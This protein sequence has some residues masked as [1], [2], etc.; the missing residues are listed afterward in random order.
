MQDDVV[1][2]VENVSK[3]FCKSLKRGMLY[4]MFDILRNSFGI[5]TNSEKL[6]LGEF[7][8][9]DD[10]SFEVK[11]GEI[12][13]IIGMN[14]SGKTTLLKMLNG[15]FWPDKGKITIHGRTGAL[16]ALG[17]GF[18]PNLTGRENIFMNGAILG[19]SKNEIESKLDE[20]IA[21]A[22]I[23]DFIDTPVK[24]YSSGM[25]VKLGFATAINIDPEVL[26][27]DEVLS[28]GDL[29]FQ[30]KSLRR[31]QELRKKASAAVFVSH[32][33]S[34]MR[35]ICDRLLVLDHGRKVFYG[36]VDEG[37]KFYEE[38]VAKKQVAVVTGKE[39][40]HSSN[41]FSDQFK[42]NRYGLLDDNG[43][44][45]NEIKFDQNLILF[46]DFEFFKDV[47]QLVFAVAVQNNDNIICLYEWNTDSLSDKKSFT[48]VRM[49][50]YRLVVKYIKPQLIPGFYA[51]LI[52]VRNTATAETY[53]KTRCL[54][55]RIKI[56][57]DVLRNGI[58]KTNSYW[59][60]KKL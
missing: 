8:A 29:S 54:D 51:P 7:W 21:F 34:H 18:H 13:G 14:G 22:D 55:Y 41:V 4:G 43:K 37:I 53:V 36:E 25:T 2:K 50:K 33:L 1:I 39:D 19:M 42:L 12:L 46:F 10:L 58:V 40:S 5:K 24:F 57:G 20:I 28:V 35:S 49:G 56:T 17:A 31:L 52:T 23:G 15:I 47:S 44:E 6:R 11:K 60:L 9:V 27:I 45:I 59:Q 30:N 26:L 38:V 3:K 16:I 32:R 48:N